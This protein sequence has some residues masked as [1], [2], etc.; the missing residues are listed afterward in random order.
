MKK[1]N[2][3]EETE[4][5]TKKKRRF[6]FRPFYWLAVLMVIG[7][8]CVFVAIGGFCYYIVKSAPEFDVDKMFEKYS[9]NQI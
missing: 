7:A 2:K 1:R 8:L 5:K 9:S 3:K 4:T 6:R